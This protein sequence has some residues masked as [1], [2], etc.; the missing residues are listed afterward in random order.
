[1]NKS[2]INKINRVQLGRIRARPRYTV[3]GAAHGHVPR[4]R[5]VAARAARVRSA[6]PARPWPGGARGG[7][8]PRRATAR[9]RYTETVGRRRRGVT[10]TGGRARR[11]QRRGSDSGRTDMA[12]RGGGGA[13]EA[14]ATRCTGRGGGRRRGREA[15]S[16]GGGARL[17]VIFKLKIYP[18]GN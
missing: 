17:S 15:Q 2:E 7:A 5:P 6:G 16:S 14:V 4:P 8:A 10:A 12:G 11:R 18:E 1:L 9:C 13:G 3:R